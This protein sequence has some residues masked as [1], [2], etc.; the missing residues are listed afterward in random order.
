RSGATGGGLSWADAMGDLRI[1]LERTQ[2]G[3]QVWV[4]EGVYTPDPSNR[5]RYFQPS[6]DVTILGGFPASG[7]PG[8][9]QRDPRARPTILSG[10]I[11][12]TGSGADDS[13][14]VMYLYY[15][16]QVVID[17][18]ILESA[19]YTNFYAYGCNG[20]AV[21]NCVVRGARGQGGQGGGLHVSYGSAALSGLLVTANTSTSNGGGAAFYGV[22]GRLDNSVFVGNALTSAAG[23][24]AGIYLN[25]S[26]L[27]ARHLTIA[28]NTIPG[29]AAGQGG[30]LYAI[31][32]A[33]IAD[34]ILCANLPD[35]AGPLTGTGNADLAGSLIEGGLPTSFAGAGTASGAAQFTD[36]LA[37]AGADGRF[38]TA[39]DGWSLAP[40]DTLAAD[41]ASAGGPD[42]DIARTP[43]PQ[44][45]FA[46]R[47]A[48]E[49]ATGVVVPDTTAPALAIT[50]PASGLVAT[51]YQTITGTVGT[52]AVSLTWRAT[53][54][55]EGSG[56]ITIAFPWSFGLSLSPG[57]TE[58]EIR[59]RDAAGNTAVRTRTLDVQR[60][61]LAM[62]A[63]IADRS[64]DPAVV[65]FTRTAL[66]DQPLAVDYT[67][68]GSATTSSYQPLSGRIT[69]PA[70]SGTGDLQIFAID[71]GRPSDDR[72][73]TVALAASTAWQIGSP[74]SRTV[75]IGDA[76]R[77]LALGVAATG[78][79][80][81]A[82]DAD[83]FTFTAPVLAD[84]R[85]EL[86]GSGSGAGTLYDP[87]LVLYGP[88]SA[89]I[90]VARDEDGLGQREALIARTLA[91]GTYFVEVTGYS[92][93]TGT[94]EV[95]ASLT[96][97]TVRIT[98]PDAVA[99]EVGPDQGRFAV[100]RVGDLSFPLTVDIAWSGSVVPGVDTQSLPSSVAFAPGQ[101]VVDIPVVPVG[102]ALSEGDEFL[103]AT[104]QPSAAF[105]LGTPAQATMVL[106]DEYART[107]YVAAGATG[108]GNGTSWADAYPRLEQALVAALPGDQV[109]VAA[110]LYV[111][112]TGTDQ[113]ASFTVGSQV[114]VFGGFAGGE[115]S[116]QDRDPDAHPVVLSGEIGAAGPGDNS[117]VV[118]VMQPGSVLDGVTV[119]DGDGT[120]DGAGVR[121]GTA[122]DV[123]IVRC[124]ILANR[125]TANGAGLSIAAGGGA[126]VLGTVFEGN[127]AGGNGG[128]IAN[129]SA[130][131]A[132]VNCVFTANAAG[133]G[134]AVYTGG[135]LIAS[136]TFSGNSA[137]SQAAAVYTTDASVVD[138]ILWG[139]V[140]DQLRMTAAGQLRNA[141]VRG[142]TAGV[143]GSG[144]VVV[145]V[146]ASSPLFVSAGDPRLTIGSPAIDA[147]DAARAPGSDLRGAPRV[148]A[149][150]LG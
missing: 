127:V 122:T 19:A 103:V 121:I 49:R 13:Y 9:A 59:A 137:T 77:T 131:S 66:L 73:L 56:T 76:R 141:I 22:N 125:T 11:G 112:T 123:A 98:A 62:V 88:D 139:P 90:E 42:A 4:A 134:G 45:G 53:G 41:Q 115:T 26:G 54:S 57:R 144:A 108:A 75:L 140:A 71:D 81:V 51:S 130:R 14:Y 89:A 150:D 23:S 147:A 44:G 40:T 80:D 120:A 21:T 5:G 86:R 29:G 111:P 48:Y 109:W 124:R 68:S 101:A 117:D 67:V 34:S 95:K 31:G 72:T 85:I 146:S 99:G 35:Q 63:G 39:D 36:V 107:L 15:D 128:A 138:S 135:A 136:S 119:R 142:G 97:P 78:S 149:A 2:P 6:S 60:V 61:S 79:I 18:F 70:G 12:D 126:T 52:D 3:D 24:G 47:G 145:A 7:D 129:A 37:P 38:L 92:T 104:V 46:D 113:A 8:M 50:A 32:G 16:Q 30:G 94:Y 55:T 28:G 106:R 69:L 143:T 102:D 100:S 148:G 74:S 91:P 116:R 25:G 118:V 96:A 114:S 65:R 64:G 43:R 83:R 84:Y 1:A 27:D 17:G 58:I 10:N 33:V 20:L 82:E 110:G 133:I 87:S 93:Y 105:T 132:F